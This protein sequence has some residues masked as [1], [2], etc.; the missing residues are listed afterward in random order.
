MTPIDAYKYT[1]IVLAE[2]EQVK[3]ITVKV[4]AYTAGGNPDQ[5]AK[6]KE[7]YE[8]DTG[9]IPA[10]LWVNAEINFENNAQ[11]KMLYEKQQHLGWMGIAFDL[12]GLDKRRDW[13]L[14]WSFRYLPGDIDQEREDRT[15][16]VEDMITDM[17]RNKESS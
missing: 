12:G 16:M 2:L 10:H 15:R 1:L 11:S 14:D 4:E 7:K 3:G 9:R 5:L 17:D 13:S 6:L 8:S